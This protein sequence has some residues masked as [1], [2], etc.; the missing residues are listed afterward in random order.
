MRLD[1]HDIFPLSVIVIF[2]IAIPIAL[3]VGF[4]SRP[5][6]VRDVY[7]TTKFFAFASVAVAVFIAWFTIRLRRRET[8]FLTERGEQTRSDFAALFAGEF[9]QR[10]AAL[11]FQRLRGMTAT[12]RM[13]KLK[14]EDTLSGPPLFLVSDDL[15]EQIG[16]LCEELDICTALDPDARTALYDSKTVSQLVSALARFIE[17]QGLKS[18]V[19]T[20]PDGTC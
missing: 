10:A 19:V 18:H 8:R 13:P 9:E 5:Q 2:A 1:K 16:E 7:D 11:L 15:A 3:W 12:G 20:T 14:K 6:I 17:Q 4:G